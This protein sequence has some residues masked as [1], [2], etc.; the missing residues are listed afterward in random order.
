M[1]TLNRKQKTLVSIKAA[2]RT[3]TTSIT[4][5]ASAVKQQYKKNKAYV[6]WQTVMEASEHEDDETLGDRL[7]ETVGKVKETIKDSTEHLDYRRKERKILKW[8]HKLLNDEGIAVTPEHVLWACEGL[9]KSWTEDTSDDDNPEKAEW[10]AV[11][12]A[13]IV[14]RTNDPALTY[15]ESQKV[16]NDQIVN[17]GILKE[18][19]SDA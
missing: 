11:L 15:E 17:L 2:T 6:T 14:E 5:K 8:V 3:V 18:Q 13:M 10:V 16:W 9:L 7:R 4:H 12:Q 1:S 19:T